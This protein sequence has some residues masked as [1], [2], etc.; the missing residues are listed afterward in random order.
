MHSYIVGKHTYTE[1]EIWH[2]GPY[3]LRVMW[4]T[5]RYSLVQGFCFIITLYP[6]MMAQIIMA[7]VGSMYT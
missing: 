7:I 1:D 5:R 4:V 6:P 3:K 2:H